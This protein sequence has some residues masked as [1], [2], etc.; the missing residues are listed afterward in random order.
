M[1]R[2]RLQLG[3]SGGRP[4]PVSAFGWAMGAYSFSMRDRTIPVMQE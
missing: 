4:A 3:M 1:M 2:L